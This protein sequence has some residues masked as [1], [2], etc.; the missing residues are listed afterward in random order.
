[1]ECL[2]YLFPEVSFSGVFI[3]FESFKFVAKVGGLSVSG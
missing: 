1:M 3:V 2:L